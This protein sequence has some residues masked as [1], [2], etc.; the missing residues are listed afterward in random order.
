MTFCPPHFC[1][2][3]VPL[4]P[5]LPLFSIF[6]NIYLMMQLDMSTW[7]RF[8]VWMAIGTAAPFHLHLQGNSRSSFYNF[9]LSL[10]QGS[11]S[12]SSTVSR[13]AARAATSPHAST[14]LLSRPRAPFTREP[15]LT[16]TGRQTAPDTCW[17]SP[18]SCVAECLHH[19]CWVV[20]KEESRNFWE[21]RTHL[22]SDFGGWLDE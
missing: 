12:I 4:L 17:R 2:L 16:A 21:G 8:T 20:P 10:Q 14:S 5:W 9:L 7:I 11:P 3:Q 22:T 19:S 6:V 13:T 1:L 15:P 18:S